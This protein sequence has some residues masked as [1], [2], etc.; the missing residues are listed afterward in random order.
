M[1]NG[2][3]GGFVVIYVLDNQIFTTYILNKYKR[4]SS[5]STFDL[6]SILQCFFWYLEKHNDLFCDL[7]HYNFVI[8]S[9]FMG[10]VMRKEMNQ[11]LSYNMTRYEFII[12]W[13]A[14]LLSFHSTH[15]RVE[16]CKCYKLASVVSFQIQPLR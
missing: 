3:I 14:N 1:P 10:L 2:F 11:F 5:K 16:T 9:L 4:S 8:H 12:Q 15:L 7:W 6:K 13:Y